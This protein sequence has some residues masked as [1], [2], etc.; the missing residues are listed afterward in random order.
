MQ[1]V[2]LVE[3]GT[4]ALLVGSLFF[5]VLLVRATSAAKSKEPLWRPVLDSELAR[6]K[7]LSIEQ[8]LE[9]L[10]DLQAYL[11]DYQGQAF[12]VEVE[13][14]ENTAVY[15]HAVVAVCDG[16]LPESIKPLAESFICR[17]S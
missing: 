1:F 12:Q 5:I 11:V 3:Y 2:S 15:V 8:L 14:I 16:E 7:A 17:K 4:I 9:Q 6:W 10:V 13:L